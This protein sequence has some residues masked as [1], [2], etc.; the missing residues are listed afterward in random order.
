MRMKKI[1]FVTFPLLFLFLGCANEVQINNK[2]LTA[3]MPW[4]YRNLTDFNNMDVLYLDCIKKDGLQSIFSID[5][6]VDLTIQ[7][8]S[9]TILEDTPVAVLSRRFRSIKH[10]VDNDPAFGWKNFTITQAPKAITFKGLPA[11][12]GIFEVEEYIKS[13]DQIIQ[14]RIKRL[15]V[16]V[17]NDLW[18]IVLAP[19]QLKH[20]ED[21][22][23]TFEQI[24]ESIKIKK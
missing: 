11:A 23:H 20:Y 6:E 3:T 13:T 12:E 16:F 14:K 4:E 8:N 19:S 7:P 22:M 9:Q 2:Y 24:L 5:H 17:D 10:S 21:E 18:N 15:V 1:T